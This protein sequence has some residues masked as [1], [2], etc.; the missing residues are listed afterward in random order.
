MN[1][2]VAIVD[3]GSSKADWVFTSGQRRMLLELPGYNP[4][5]TSQEQYVQTVITSLPSEIIPSEI[6]AIYFYA[7]G[8]TGP[9]RLLQG[10]RMLQAI[11]PSADL[12]IDSDLMGAA[13]AV[14]GN[15]PGLV[16]ILGTGSNACI[17][18]GK[19]IR[20]GINSLG[21]ILGDEGSG[22]Y[23][24]KQLIKDYFYYLLPSDL[25]RKFTEEYQLTKDGLLNA[26]YRQP[27]P[28]FYLASFTD[29]LGRHRDHPYIQMMLDQAFSQF[30]EKHLLR[31]R[32]FRY[33]RTHLI[34]SIAFHFADFVRK[35][36][37]KYNLPVGLIV[38][39]PIDRLVDFIEGQ[40]F[41]S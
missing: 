19:K 35:A 30:A 16:G 31:F 25:A 36:L 13:L 2:N 40:H 17:F 26:I 21:W 10:K 22:T 1:Y 8:M 37:A 6:F 18:D 28:N 3:S 41:R 12:T 38:K 34:G 9:E 39:K 24:G 14:C 20:D 15:E 11:F 5:I 7:A 29:F 4:L 33:L 32:Q 27:R 23:L